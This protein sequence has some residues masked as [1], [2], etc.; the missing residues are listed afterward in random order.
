LNRSPTKGVADKTPYEAWFGKKPYVHHLRTFGCVAYVKN[1]TPHLKKL[2]DRSRAMIFVGMSQARKVTECMIPP[3]SEFR[4]HMMWYLMSKHNGTGKLKMV[5]RLMWNR[6]SLLTIQLL[7]SLQIQI[8]PQEKM[9]EGI[10]MVTVLTLWQGMVIMG[11]M[12]ETM[13]QEE[14]LHW[15]A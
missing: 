2:D 1:T 11:W 15:Q 14:S 4:Y 3:L 7:G 13:Y 8:T 9:K 10:E 12:M 5:Q 6:V